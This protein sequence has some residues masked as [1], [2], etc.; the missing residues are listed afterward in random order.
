V[1]FATKKNQKFVYS[2]IHEGGIDELERRMLYMWLALMKQYWNVSLFRQEPSTTPYSVFLLWI[3]GIAFYVL[4]VLQWMISDINQQLPFGAALLVAGTLALSYALYTWILLSLFRL[5]SRF[6]QT[7][8]CLFA[9][10]TAVHLLAFPLL[11][12]MPMLIG[13]Q[14]TPVIGS[15]VG[16]IYLVLT[17][18]LAIWQ[19]MVSTYIYK[20]ALSAP[21]FSAVLASFGLLAFNILTVSLWR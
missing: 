15:F 5:K 4:I 3:V 17:L 19:F 2:F 8:T 11:L 14:G 13:A 10:H 21:Y 20:H 9:G 7:L 1:I 6:V 18:M 12:T 16:I